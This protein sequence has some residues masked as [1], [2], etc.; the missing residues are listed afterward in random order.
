M[1]NQSRSTGAQL[2]D[3]SDCGGS[4]QSTIISTSLDLNLFGDGD[5]S[6]SDFKKAVSLSFLANEVPKSFHF[7]FS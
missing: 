5:C 2:E 4:S 7:G 6:S 3:D 1:V